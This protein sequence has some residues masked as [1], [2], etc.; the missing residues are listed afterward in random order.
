VVDAG[1]EL[2]VGGAGGGELV[3]AFAEL[4]PQVGGRTPI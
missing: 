1:H 4:D 2:A 3:V